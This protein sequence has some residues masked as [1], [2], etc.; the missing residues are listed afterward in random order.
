MLPPWNV[1]A[2]AEEL[3]RI[4]ATCSRE[5]ETGRRK[6]VRDSKALEF[7]LSQLDGLTAFPTNANFVYCEL[8]ASIPGRQLRDE[9][10][11]QSGCFVRECGSKIGSGSQFLRIATRPPNQQHL[12]MKALR[13]AFTLIQRGDGNSCGLVALPRASSSP[14][15][16]TN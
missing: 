15:N 11:Q 12:L 5:Y 13:K 6:V 14:E 1:N 9:L 3:I 10:L 16:R 2:L 4:V 8:D 7:R